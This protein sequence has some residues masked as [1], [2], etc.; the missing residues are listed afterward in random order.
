M[1]LLIH[2]EARLE[3]KLKIIPFV[4]AKIC[5]KPKLKVL[6]YLNIIYKNNNNK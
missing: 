1:H 5:N 3:L 2:N 6:I 4:F